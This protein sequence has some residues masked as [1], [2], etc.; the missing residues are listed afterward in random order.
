ARFR[1]AFQHAPIGIG[2]LSAE[3]R[4][5]QANG[6]M[7][8]I[9]GFSEAELTERSIRDVLHP[10]DAERELA[11]FAQLL[12][13]RGETFELEQCFRHASGK[14]VW[15][16]HN[17]SQVRDSDD[18]LLYFICQVLDITDRNI[19]LEETRRA[20]E[21]LENIIRSSTDGILAF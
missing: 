12:A 10:D 3:G 8:Q 18:R 14:R 20:K 2:L 6:A 15:V 4:W 7:T 1:E 19:A 13:Q 17:V 5:L 9:T 11:R 16:L 21:F